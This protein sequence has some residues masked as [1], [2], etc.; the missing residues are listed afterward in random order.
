[1]ESI[2]RLRSYYDSAVDSAALWQCSVIFAIEF[3]EFA[4]AAL[5]KRVQ[6]SKAVEADALF[7]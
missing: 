6:A 2:S 7:K 3:S 4:S 5:G 1:M